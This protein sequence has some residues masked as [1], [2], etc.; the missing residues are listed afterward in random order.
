MNTIAQVATMNQMERIVAKALMPASQNVEDR[1][2]D[3]ACQPSGLSMIDSLRSQR[4]L[5][6]DKKRPNS[7]LIRVMG[8]RWLESGYRMRLGKTRGIEGFRKFSSCR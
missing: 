6:L 2:R 1:D 8:S 3:R 5:R 4:G 7:G